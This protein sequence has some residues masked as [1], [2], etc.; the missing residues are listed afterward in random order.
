MLAQDEALPGQ[1]YLWLG[2][3]ESFDFTQAS[4]VCD[5]TFGHDVHSDTLNPL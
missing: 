4:R 5:T 2:R 1:N 3:M